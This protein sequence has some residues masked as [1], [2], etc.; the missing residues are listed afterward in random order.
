[1]DIDEKI[2]GMIERDSRGGYYLEY[3]GRITLEDARE[4]AEWILRDL[5]DREQELDPS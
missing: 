3:Y 5:Q 2:N 4:L 1:M